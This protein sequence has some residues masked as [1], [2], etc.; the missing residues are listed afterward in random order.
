MPKKSKGGNNTRRFAIKKLPIQ[1][2]D[3]NISQI[4]GTIQEVSG[5]S[6]FKVK[7]ILDEIRTCSMTG[8]VKNNGRLRLGD[9]VLIEPLSTNENGMYII[10]FRYTP[11]Q[12]KVLEKEGCITKKVDPSIVKEEEEEED[13]GFVFEDEAKEKQMAKEMELINE[14]FVDDI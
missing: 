6:Q 11:D 1:Y 2:A 8:A 9:F 7:T 14:L 3:T 4:Y 5:P 13:K 12:K 10:V